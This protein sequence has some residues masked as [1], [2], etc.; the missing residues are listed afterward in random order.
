[1]FLG[2]DENGMVVGA[3]A[4]ADQQE[5]ARESKRRREYKAAPRLPQISEL[6]GGTMN[7]GDL[8]WDETMFKK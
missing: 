2:S 7:D 6:V 1:M 4:G 3:G 8:G 5:P